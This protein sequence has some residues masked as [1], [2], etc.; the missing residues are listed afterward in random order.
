MSGAEELVDG[1]RQHGQLP[2]IPARSIKRPHSQRCWPND[3]APQSSN[4]YTVED[5]FARAAGNNG[6]GRRGWRRR[7]AAWRHASEHQRGARPEGSAPPH[8]GQ[9]AVTQT[10]RD[11]T[12]SLD[13]AV[14]GFPLDG[15]QV[16]K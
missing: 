10:L 3:R 13:G 15:A 14:L 9:L 5:F 12:L 6:C 8:T 16:R 1:D 7:Q 4:S 11:G 2:P